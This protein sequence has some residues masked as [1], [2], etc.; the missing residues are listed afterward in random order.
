MEE[1][2]GW[3]GGMEWENRKIEREKAAMTGSEGEPSTSAIDSLFLEGCYL[4][5]R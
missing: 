5:P 3:G 1:N 2:W 4:L